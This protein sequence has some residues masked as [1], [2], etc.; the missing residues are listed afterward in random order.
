MIRRLAKDIVRDF[1]NARPFSTQ[2]KMLIGAMAGAA[3]CQFTIAA[4]GLYAAVSCH[5]SHDENSAACHAN[6]GVQ[7]VLDDNKP[8]A[9]F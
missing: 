7:E 2:D 5:N 6:R 4:I 3:A 1:N 8:F 9:L